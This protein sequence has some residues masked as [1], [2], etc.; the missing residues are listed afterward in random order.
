MMEYG[1]SLAEFV[2]KVGP[3]IRFGYCDA[4]GLRP[5]SGISGQT[6]RSIPFGGD[7]MEKTTMQETMIKRLPEVQELLQDMVV[8]LRFRGC[9]D[10]HKLLQQ[11]RIVNGWLEEANRTFQLLPNDSA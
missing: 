1:S 11:A 4:R 8:E 7:S 2:G 6:M 9:D 5:W 3:E 10:N